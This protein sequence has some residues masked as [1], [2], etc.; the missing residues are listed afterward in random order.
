MMRCEI[1]LPIPFNL[2]SCTVSASFTSNSIFLKTD[3][4]VETPGNAVFREF[5]FDRVLGVVEVGEIDAIRI[6]AAAIYKTEFDSCTK[7]M[8]SSQSILSNKLKDEMPFRTAFYNKSV[9]LNNAIKN[10]TIK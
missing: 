8:E 6:P 5:E 1:L 7:E 9:A 10:N 4:G 2:T 3:P